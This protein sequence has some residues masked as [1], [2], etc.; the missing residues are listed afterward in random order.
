MRQVLLILLAAILLLPV[1]LTAQNRDVPYW[2]SLRHEEAYMRVGPS[3]DYKIDWVYK[4]KHLPVIVIREIDGWK[5]VRDPDG[6]EGWIA[7]SQVSRNLYAMIDGEGWA[8]IRADPADNAKL[9]WNAEPGVIGALGKCEL[10]WCEF[11]ISGRK[12]WVK[13]DRLWGAGAL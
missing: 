11:D 3:K 12:G 9:N 6:V 7:H 5:R 8:A 1:P 4:R 2:A 10:R 13:Q